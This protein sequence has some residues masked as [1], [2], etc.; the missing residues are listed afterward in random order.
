MSLANS[1]SFTSPFPIRITFIS[2]SCIIVVAKTSNQLFLLF[3]F[4]QCGFASCCEF[5]PI[6]R[7]IFVLVVTR[8]FFSLHSYFWFLLVLT[9][10]QLLD[11]FFPFLFLTFCM[12][13]LLNYKHR[14][15]VVWWQDFRTLNGLE[16][17]VWRCFMTW[18]SMRHHSLVTRGITCED[19]G[20][21][22]S[23]SFVCT[24]AFTLIWVTLAS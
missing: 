18:P 16:S 20:S 19:R 23:Y 4:L 22:E 17:L 3:F 10:H 2:L 7:S 12:F 1:E 8:L 11:E 21:F 15:T 24:V 9:K 14:Y 13:P 5:S 6:F